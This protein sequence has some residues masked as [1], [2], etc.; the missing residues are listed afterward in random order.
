MIFIKNIFSH[1]NL[2]GAFLLVF[3]GLLA[4]ASNGLVHGLSV[5][6]PVFQMVFFKTGTSLILL[7]ILFRGRIQKVAKTQIIRVHAL[8][9]LFGALGN[10]F[11]FGALLYL[12]LA[13]SAALSLASALFTSLGGFFFF[14]EPFRKAVWI[15]LAVGFLGVFLILDPFAHAFHWGI[16]LPLASAFFF[17]GSSLIIKPISRSDSSQTTLFY[18]MVFMCL[19]SLV[20]TLM[21]WQTPAWKDLL[22]LVIVGVLYTGTQLSLIEAYTHSEASFIAPFKFARFPLSMLVGFLFFSEIPHVYT[23]LG[24]ALILAA[25][26]MLIFHE[27]RRRQKERLKR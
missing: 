12:P 22:R 17:S 9:S 10:F 15:G 20:P 13:Q 23:L 2:F 3:G 11:W 7:L 4:S 27:K 25:N 8:K 16:L 19:F 18:L 1:S 24:G 14:K 6:L 26:F 21:V 5:S